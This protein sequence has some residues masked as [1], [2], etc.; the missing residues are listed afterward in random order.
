M[1]VPAQDTGRWHGEV[2]TGH[3][4]TRHEQGTRNPNGGR[5]GR[6]QATAG[7]PDGGRQQD[8]AGDGQAAVIELGQAGRDAPDARYAQRP[9]PRPHHQRH[10]P[11]NV[12]GQCLQQPAGY[13]GHRRSGQRHAE[14]LVPAH[15]HSRRQRQPNCGEQPSGRGQ[16]EREKA[17]R[18]RR[19]PALRQDHGCFTKSQATPHRPTGSGGWRARPS[20]PGA[21]VFVTIDLVFIVTAVRRQRSGHA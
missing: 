6:C 3:D 14:V 7:Q 17:N 1:P 10:D 19:R 18:H 21:P 15:H 16:H 11:V 12:T 20:N 4:S 8:V 9:Q 2:G 13:R 5:R